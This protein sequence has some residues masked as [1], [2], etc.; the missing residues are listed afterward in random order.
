MTY[1]VKDETLIVLRAQ[2]C[3]RKLLRAK[4]ACFE[5]VG[6]GRLD[7]NFKLCMK[8]ILN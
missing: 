5:A 3:V 4:A 7:T 8:I 2:V 1:L 6:V